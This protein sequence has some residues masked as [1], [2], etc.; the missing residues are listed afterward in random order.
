MGV[1]TVLNKA[2]YMQLYQSQRHDI[3]TLKNYSQYLIF[4]HY[5][6][7]QLIEKD[8]STQTLKNKWYDEECKFGIEEMKKAREEWLIK[9]RNGER[10]AG[11]SQ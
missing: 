5:Y 8:E 6:N 11:V 1:I 3:I 10:R 7:T 9:G 4:S 2:Y